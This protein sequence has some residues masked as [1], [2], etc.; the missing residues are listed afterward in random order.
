MDSRFGLTVWFSDGR[1]GKGGKD[2]FREVQGSTRFMTV[3][4]AG[5][6]CGAR[7]R[8][9]NWWGR[10]WGGGNAREKWW[11]LVTERQDHILYFASDCPASKTTVQPF[12]GETHDFL[13]FLPFG[14]EKAANSS[15]KMFI[16]WCLSQQAP[17][18]C[19]GRSHGSLETYLCILEKKNQ[20]KTSVRRPDGRKCGQLPPSTGEVKSMTKGHWLSLMNRHENCWFKGE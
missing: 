12:L 5:C 16:H 9:K 15:Q 7:S 4:I 8:A 3:W 11:R 10:D 14:V 18:A 6:L 13:W 17:R 19:G 20:S 2:L 1:I